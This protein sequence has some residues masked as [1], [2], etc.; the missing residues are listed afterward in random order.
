MNFEAGNETRENFLSF[1][2][3]KVEELNESRMFFFVQIVF[4]EKSRN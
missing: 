2:L 4:L 3:N 1:V